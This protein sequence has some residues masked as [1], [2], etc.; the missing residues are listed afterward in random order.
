VRVYFGADGWDDYLYWGRSDA[1]VH[2]RLNELIEDA[3]RQPFV[4][5]GKPE[6]LR[7]DLSG[8]WSRRITAEHQELSGASWPRLFPSRSG[9]LPGS[10]LAG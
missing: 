6:A 1:N 2:R 9:A 5:L 7:G 4:G 10:A 8:W 3:R